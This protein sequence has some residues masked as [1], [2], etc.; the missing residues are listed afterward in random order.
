MFQ[1]L[2]KGVI[3]AGDREEAAVVAA[4]L[5]RQHGAEVGDDEVAG[6]AAGAGLFAG[7]AGDFEERE[8][9][10]WGQA[11]RVAALHIV[12]VAE[13]VLGERSKVHVV[14]PAHQAGRDGR[15]GGRELQLGQQL[16]A[17]FLRFL[18]EKI[19][20]KQSP[21]S[22]YSFSTLKKTDPKK[23]EWKSSKIRMK[24]S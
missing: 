7:V 11:D 21:I 20:V 2:G 4:R 23:S 15:G 12:H 19:R 16:G 6:F 22:D 1:G 9:G 5:E 14:P 17:G 13:I 18:C 10:G 8:G 3:S 24:K